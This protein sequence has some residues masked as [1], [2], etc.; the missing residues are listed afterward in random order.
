MMVGVQAPATR[1][2]LLTTK[3]DEP[4]PRIEELEAPPALER[5]TRLGHASLGAAVRVVALTTRR[6]GL[7]AGAPGDGPEVPVARAR[8]LGR[9]G[10]VTTTSDGRWSG[11]AIGTVSEG[12]RTVLC[13]DT[14]I[15]TPAVRTALQDLVALGGRALVT[16]RLE[17]EAEQLRLL[18]GTASHDLRNP[19]SVLRAGLETLTLHGDRLPD[20]QAERIA[21]LAVRQAVRMETMIDGLLTLHS[22]DEAPPSDIVDVCDLVTEAVDAAR[23][24]NEGTAIELS[25]GFPCDEVPITGDRDALARMLTNLLS[26]A[27]T[28]GGGRVWVSLTVTDDRA[29][30]SVADDGPGLPDDSALDTGERADRRGGHGLGLVIAQRVALLHGGSITHHDRGHGGTVVEVSLPR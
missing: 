2:I 17:R 8:E 18:L 6:A 29:C 3:D 25:G 4:V 9:S 27:A 12:V 13:V 15:R 28:H 20:G 7:V 16:E 23:L 14:A 24:G 5:L 10:A 22:T 19:L 21:E 26:N 30:V 1:S 11:A